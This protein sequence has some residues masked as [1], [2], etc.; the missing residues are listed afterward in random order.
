MRPL[1]LSCLLMILV[2]G[3]SCGSRNIPATPS[4]QIESATIYS[5]I[6]GNP[7][8][9]QSF[10]ATLSLGSLNQFG[11]SPLTG[12]QP[13]SIA[14]TPSLNALFVD[15]SGSNTISAYAINS[16]GSL[17]ATGT[18]TPTGAY[19]TGMA[20]DPRGRFL[21]VANQ[22]SSSISVYSING[23]SLQPVAGSPFTTIPPGTKTPTLPTAVAVSAT[24]NFL[25]VANNFINSVGAFSVA[26]SGAL[27]PLGAS[28]YTLCPPTVPCPAAPSGLAVTP[29]GGFLYVAN[30]GLATVSAFAICDKVVTTCTNPNLP[31]GTLTP[32][33]GSPFAAGLGPIAVAVDP[34]FS[35]LYVLNKQSFQISEYSYSPGSGVLSSLSTPAVST[36][37]TPLSFVIVAGATGS[38]AGFTTTEPNDFVFVANSGASTLTV[39][40]LNTTTG[41]LTPL[42]AA[43]NIAGNPAAVAAP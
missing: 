40:T 13:F 38:N 37:Q 9:I 43:T 41:V 42:G 2:C 11:A 20:V 14:I 16:S 23:T 22:A 8:Y 26:A 3:L 33:T 18:S 29:G 36:G 5:A 31:D 25:Y 24:G 17:Q 30:T 28:P 6:L 10:T 7:G 4:T 15:N 21:F 39:F 12:S 19:P 34:H 27:M 32:V 35:F 1:F